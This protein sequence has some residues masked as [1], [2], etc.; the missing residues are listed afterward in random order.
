ML[1]FRGEV[2]VSGDIICASGV[3]DDGD[4]I[5]NGVGMEFLEEGK[6][7]SW[8]VRGLLVRW[9]LW[10]TLPHTLHGEGTDLPLNLSPH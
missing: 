2:G 6:R 7:Q 9:C 3:E 10:N 8:Q 5:D 4:D 1:V